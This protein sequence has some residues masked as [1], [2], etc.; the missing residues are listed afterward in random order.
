MELFS[1]NCSLHTASPFVSFHEW[2]QFLQH[3]FLVAIAQR[4][5]PLLLGVDNQP[6]EMLLFQVSFMLVGSPKGRMRWREQGWEA[7]KCSSDCAPEVAELLACE[8]SSWGLYWHPG[9]QLEMVWSVLTQM[10]QKDWSDGDFPTLL[11]LC[12][13]FYQSC[14][15][16]IHLINTLPSLHWKKPFKNPGNLPGTASRD[17]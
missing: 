12:G 11:S 16:K 10:G 13:S 8:T 9:E 1:L 17:L 6:S 5:Q 15:R 7:G 3:S 4:S 14:I 2:I